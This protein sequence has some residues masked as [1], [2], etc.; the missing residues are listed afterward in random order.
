MLILFFKF[1]IL[2]SIPNMLN[3]ISN[4]SL[5]E[6]AII[7]KIERGRR[8]SDKERNIETVWVRAGHGSLYLTVDRHIFTA[9]TY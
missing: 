4:N 3:V 6:L 7:G 2:I 5:E 8:E 9:M 1:L